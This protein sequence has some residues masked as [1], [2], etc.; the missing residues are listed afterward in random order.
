MP[1][2]EVA[3]PMEMVAGSV[4]WWSWQ[5]HSDKKGTRGATALGS[6]ATGQKR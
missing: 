4:R 6:S 3:T 5:I 1:Q 2:Y